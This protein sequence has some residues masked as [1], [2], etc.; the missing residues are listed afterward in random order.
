M[1]NRSKWKVA[2][3]ESHHLLLREHRRSGE[4]LTQRAA[5]EIDSELSRTRGVVNCDGEQ[6]TPS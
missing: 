6:G 3:N 2:C 4:E 5:V 1:R